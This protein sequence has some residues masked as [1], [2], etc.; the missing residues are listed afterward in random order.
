MIE[1][2]ILYSLKS[3]NRERTLYSLRSDIIEKFGYFTKPSIGTIHPA[4]KR[5]LKAN[6]VTIRNDYS[7]GGKKSTYYG[8]AMHWTKK[9]HDLFF[10][11]LSENPT[12]FFTEV[13]TRIAVMSLLDDELKQTFINDILIKMESLQLDLK[14]ALDDEYTTFDKY[15]LALLKK[16]ITDIENYK[17]FI[18]NIE[19]NL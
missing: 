6:V 18:R 16:N 10:T 4:L 3:K 19:E 8:L 9:F 1:L 11:P 12:Q 13:Q 14:N 17:I 7:Q 2:L 15:Q 5:L